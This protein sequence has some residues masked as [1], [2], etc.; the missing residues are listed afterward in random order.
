MS[1]PLCPYSPAAE[2]APIRLLPCH[3]PLPLPPRPPQFILS[4]PPMVLSSPAK[5][6]A[7]GAWVAPS[8]RRAVSSLPPRSLKRLVQ[9]AN[10]RNVSSKARTSPMP[11]VSSGSVAAH[12]MNTA[13]ACISLERMSPMFCGTT[14]KLN[15][16]KT[17]HGISMR[18]PLEFKRLCLSTGTAIKR[19][20]ALWTARISRVI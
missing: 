3:Q 9:P 17:S 5:T 1:L 14:T 11:S 10:L 6:T 15:R 8:P 20:A 7:R 13:A 16:Q 18:T 4:Q 19:A 2:H 12:V